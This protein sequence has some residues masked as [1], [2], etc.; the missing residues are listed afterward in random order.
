MCDILPCPH[1]QEHISQ[2]PEVYDPH[3]RDIHYKSPKAKREC[4]KQ[5]PCHHHVDHHKC[6]HKCCK[7]FT[8]DSHKHKQCC[9]WE[10]SSFSDGEIEDFEK[11]E[12]H[13]WS[14]RKMRIARRSRSFSDGEMDDVDICTVKDS[15]K[16]VAKVSKVSGLEYETDDVP[17][18]DSSSIT[19]ETSPQESASRTER[20][21]ASDV[22]GS[23]KE[24][25]SGTHVKLKERSE[26]LHK[27]ERKKK[28]RELLLTDRSVRDASHAVSARRK[29]KKAQT[30]M[31]DS[32]SMAK[33]KRQKL[34]GP[35][36]SSSPKV[37]RSA[38][39][40]AIGQ[41]GSSTIAQT[42]LIYMYLSLLEI[43]EFSVLLL[44]FTTNNV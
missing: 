28:A 21:A 5:K 24:S 39:E 34:P 6:C 14:K 13:E 19:S 37:R 35:K 10:S 30:G 4:F 23:P 2:N 42:G 44:C 29:T 22:H 20:I 7:T 38:V 11:D 36:F 33:D 9:T 1:Q 17:V 12:N 18:R 15:Q 40:S 25:I 43:S 32:S 26:N 3:D 27:D 16:V 41:V 31:K 8:R